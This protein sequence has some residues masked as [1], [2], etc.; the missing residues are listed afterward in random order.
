MDVAW[1]GTRHARG[2]IVLGMTR[3]FGFDI[4]TDL[5]ARMTTWAEQFISKSGYKRYERACAF[6]ADETAERLALRMNAVV[7]E[8]FD[9]PTTWMKRA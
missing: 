4:S 5:S 6:V 9:R 1:P 2:R 7:G 3:P 8:V